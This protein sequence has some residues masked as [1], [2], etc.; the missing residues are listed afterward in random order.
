VSRLRGAGLHP[1][2]AWRMIRQP[3]ARPSRSRTRKESLLVERADTMNP[4]AAATRMAGMR[5]ARA[6]LLGLRARR[7]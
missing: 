6:L 1:A 5:A 3:S 7:S 4:T 2:A